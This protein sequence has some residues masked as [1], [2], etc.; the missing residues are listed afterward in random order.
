L[1]RQNGNDLSPP[2]PSRATFLGDLNKLKEY[3]AVLLPCPSHEAYTAQEADNLK[4]FADQGGRVFNTHGGGFW[5]FEPTM[6]Y[7]NLVAF[8]NQ[9]D[10]SV[11]VASVDMSFPK[12]V[13][14]ADWLV[15]VGASTTLG[16]LPMDQPQWFVDG[17][18]APA[19]RW[20]YT[21]GPTTI[22][23]LTFNTPIAG[24]ECG[25]VLFSNFHVGSATA[26]GTFPTTCTSGPLSTEEK[27]I[28]Y[29]LFD[30]T[31]CVQPDVK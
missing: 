10:P 29:M 31:A 25:R 27:I 16:V 21:T 28:E 17:V 30:V 19:Q 7:G 9:N 26:V 6:Q 3:D 15:L 13:T 20:I 1:Y 24:P 11:R 2:V 4:A 12:G 22:Q 5:L 23:H 8:N 14:F 18:Q